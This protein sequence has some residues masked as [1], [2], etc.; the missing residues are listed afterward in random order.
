MAELWEQVDSQLNR[1][2]STQSLAAA[3]HV[4]IGHLHRICREVCE[5]APMEMVVKLRM[6][7]AEHLL[8]RTDLPFYSIAANVGYDSPNAFSRA[9]K[10]YA[11]LSP[12]AFRKA[13]ID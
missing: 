7:R 6:R 10:R 4:S 3:M 13:A 11:G 12:R 2:W 5:C 1:D 9:F 8:R